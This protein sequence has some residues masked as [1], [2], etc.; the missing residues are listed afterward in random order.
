MRDTNLSLRLNQFLFQRL[1]RTRH[2]AQ[3][4]ECLSGMHEALSSVPR[5][6]KLNMLVH[7]SDPA[8]W[9]LKPDRTK[10]HG[11]IQLSKKFKARL[12]HRRPYLRGKK[13]ILTY[14]LLFQID[15]ADLQSH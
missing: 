4:A 7:T 14:F 6:C 1:Y 11:H 15:R 2:G 5:L 3:L 9:E 13:K 10:D 8:A 12:G